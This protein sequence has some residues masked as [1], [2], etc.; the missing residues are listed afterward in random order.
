MLDLLWKLALAA[1]FIALLY[2]VSNHESRISQIETESI[3]KSCPKT[4]RPMSYLLSN[5]RIGKVHSF[6]RSFDVCQP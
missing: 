1:A 6:A 5:R 3:G 2:L 4:C